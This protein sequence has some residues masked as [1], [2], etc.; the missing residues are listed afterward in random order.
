M[1]KKILS[2]LLV[3]TAIIMMLPIASSAAAVTKTVDL[4]GLNNDTFGSG[5]MWDNLDC[6]LT[7]DSIDLGTTDPIGIKLPANST[8]ILNGD[9]KINAG[10]YGILCLGAVTFK[11]NGTLTINASLCGI[12]G[13]SAKEKDIVVFRSGTININNSM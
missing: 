7:L 11:G 12:S 5:Y 8:V 1:K 13:M 2:I 9:N 6:I 3:I 10:A 4:T